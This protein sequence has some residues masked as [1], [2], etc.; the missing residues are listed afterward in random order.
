ME[1]ISEKIR[2]RIQWFII[3]GQ[4]NRTFKKISLLWC[5]FGA[6]RVSR[7]L[8][9]ILDVE[10][11]YSRHTH[12]GCPSFV[13]G[14]SD[15]DITIVL[16]QDAA[17]DPNRI[18]AVSNRVEALSWF[19]FYLNPHDVRFTSREELARITRNY[20]S[21]YEFLYKPDDWVFLAGEEVRSEKA[22]DFSARKMPWHPE[23]NKWWQHLLQ[24]YLLVRK[25][26]LE[27]QYLRVFYRSALRQQLQFLAA[28]GEEIP[29]P[30]GHVD[31]ELV[32]V[33]FREDLVLR[34]LLL[35]LKRRD[36]WGKDPQRLKERIMLSILQSATE[37]FRAYPFHPKLSTFP[38]PRNKDWEHHEAAYGVLESR[39]DQ[40]R[41]LTE[42][43]K[44]VL[45][46][47]VPHSY[48]YFY[49]VDLVI[50]DSISAE[51]FSETVR[52]VE[53]AFR[54]REFYLDGHGYSITYV[55][56]SILNWPLVF[57]GSPYPFL[58]E[59]IQRYG[60]Y[61]L[62][63]EPP[64]FEKAWERKDL[65]AWCRIFLP[66]YMFTLNRRIEYSS[67]SINFCQLASI[68]LFLKTG[69]KETD[70]RVLRKRHKDL[71]KVESPSDPVWNYMLRDKP[72]RQEREKYHAAMRCLLKECRFVENLLKREE[73]GCV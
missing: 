40:C 28:L 44:G 35:D 7:L 27:G 24:H 67:R 22:L 14:H 54:G 3:R 25:E 10:A 2:I 5:K 73:S 34:P 29:K 58:K 11:V 62:W 38:Q 45:V 32:D 39:M 8:L 12:P 13:P 64:V 47:P 46:Y 16:K 36:F 61:L 50:P 66:Y 26:G 33:A 19:H 42:M 53:K 18:E 69:E 70:P 43:L 21:R 6:W 23:F 17:C 68:R 41:Q 55:P 1:I 52:V 30:M 63:P 71:F 4:K 31:D 51:R 57:L 15:L 48:P 72:R 65:V 9:K 56:E 59:H 49:Q 37:F 20:P 60:M